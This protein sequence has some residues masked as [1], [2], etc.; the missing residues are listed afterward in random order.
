MFHVK[1]TRR[2][3]IRSL[4]GS[5]AGVLAVVYCPGVLASVYCPDDF[6]VVD[7]NGGGMTMHIDWLAVA[8]PVPW[9]SVTTTWSPD[10]TDNALRNALACR[11]IAL[12]RTA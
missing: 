9:R 12:K 6:V 11:R 7:K 5:V 2:S 4:L 8:A 3:F 10:V 1:Q